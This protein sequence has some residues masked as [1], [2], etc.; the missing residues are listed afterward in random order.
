[1]NISDLASVGN[2]A[3]LPRDRESDLVGPMQTSRD[4]TSKSFWYP[5]FTNRPDQNLMAGIRT[6][7]QIR[8]PLKIFTF[9]I[10]IS[11]Y[12]D[13]AGFSDR[14]KTGALQGTPTD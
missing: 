5:D 4:Q 12:R 1:M 14:P 6:I 8:I 9:S 2:T 11:L 13:C 10:K 3:A 7:R